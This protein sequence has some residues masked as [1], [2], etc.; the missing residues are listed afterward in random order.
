MVTNLGV[1]GDVVGSL[2]VIRALGQPPLDGLAV[3]GGVV[4]VAALEA[5]PGLARGAHTL[6]GAAL[7]GLHHDITVGARAEAQVGVAPHVV[8]EGEVD[9]SLPE[10][11]RGDV[12]QHQV[13]VQQRVAARHHA[14]QRRGHP[15]ADLGLAVDTPAPHAE[16]VTAPCTTLLFFFCTLKSYLNFCC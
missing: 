15:R 6:L 9:V 11:G 12:S 4:T 14:A 13:L 10:G 2:A 16:A 7:L 1:S 3:G 5:E 8:Y